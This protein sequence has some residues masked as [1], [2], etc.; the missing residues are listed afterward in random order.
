MKLSENSEFDIRNR[1]LSYLNFC[2]LDFLV[3]LNN[4]SYA[5]NSLCID[6]DVEST[7]RKSRDFSVAKISNVVDFK[8]EN[9]R[10]SKQEDIKLFKT[11]NAICQ[12]LGIDVSSIKLS[13]GKVKKPHRKL[14]KSLKIEAGW[15][16]TLIELKNRII[17]VR[18]ADK[19]TAR[20]ARVLKRYLSKLADGIVSMEQVL[21][22]FPGK[23]EE[24]ILEFQYNN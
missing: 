8:S 15:K 22:Q 2:I 24:Q 21:E 18:S 6:L 20:E 16:G 17:K 7:K 10:W 13:K 12:R 11:L 23:S 5:L 19:F 14:L 3:L 9:C 4:Q 1:R